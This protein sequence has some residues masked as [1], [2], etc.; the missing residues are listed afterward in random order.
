MC[1]Q[2]ISISIILGLVLKTQNQGSALTIGW[3][4]LFVVLLRSDDLC[5]VMIFY[6]SSQ[7]QK[8]FSIVLLYSVQCTLYTSLTFSAH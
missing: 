8:I 2:S 3:L 4:V 5:T 6:L 7:F 1:K